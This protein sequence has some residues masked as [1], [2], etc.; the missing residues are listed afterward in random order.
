VAPKH[1]GGLER[2]LLELAYTTNLEI[3]PTS[4]AYYAPCSIDE[5]DAVLSD[6]TAR[7]RLQMDIGEDGAVTYKLIGRPT[8][9]EKPVLTRAIAPRPQPI[10]SPIAAAMFSAFIPGAG[11]IYTGRIA[12]AVLWFFVVSMGYVLVLP[13]LILHMFSMISAAASA[14]RLNATQPMLLAA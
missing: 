14:R 11:H 8:L 1:T 7:N 10:A 4:L 9:A 2:R 12:A 6:L 5:A 3:S 13:G